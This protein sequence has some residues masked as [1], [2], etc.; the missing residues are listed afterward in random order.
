MAEPVAGS[1]TTPRGRLGVVAAGMSELGKEG[2]RV[3][4]TPALLTAATVTKRG[5]RVREAFPTGTSNV[6]TGVTVMVTVVEEGGG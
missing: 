5:V 2:V 1:M 3:G 4:D 6:R